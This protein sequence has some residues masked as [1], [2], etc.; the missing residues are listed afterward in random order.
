MTS[1][2]GTIKELKQLLADTYGLYLKTQNYHWNVTG[3]NFKQLHELFEEQYQELAIMVDSIAERILIL[4]GKTPATFREFSD[5]TRISFGDSSISA[6][7]MMSDLSQDQLQIV[8]DLKKL[9]AAAAPGG[10]EGTIAMASELIAKHE[11]ACWILQ[12][13]LPGKK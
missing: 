5:L 10:D 4:G 9:I 7:E 1:N 6:E 2:A 11:K 3:P 13:H 8:A 12:N